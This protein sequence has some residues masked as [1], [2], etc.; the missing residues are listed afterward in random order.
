M[1]WM[2]MADLPTPPEPNMTKRISSRS[3]NSMVLL[4]DDEALT[5]DIFLFEL[6]WHGLGLGTCFEG[7]FN[8][9]LVHGTLIR[10]GCRCLIV[11]QITIA[12]CP[13][14]LIGQP[15]K[16][17]RISNVQRTKNKKWQHGRY[18]FC[19]INLTK[20][21]YEM[22]RK[23]DKPRALNITVMETT[24]I[25]GNESVCESSGWLVLFCA[26]NLPL[27]ICN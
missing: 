5:V 18:A 3:F 9:K 16:F 4:L 10:V 23:Q 19:P 21:F 14:F 17:W 20:R 15:A 26:V 11:G 27:I 12:H 8:R 24:F 1:Y 13:W 2:E 6:I 7:K 25:N 22:L